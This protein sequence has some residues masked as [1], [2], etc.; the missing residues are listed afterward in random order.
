MNILAIIPA[1]SGSRGIPN[2]NINSFNGKPLI[3]YAIELARKAEKRGLITGHIVSTDS[4]QIASIAKEAGGNVP[5]LRPGEL[6]TDSSAVVGTAVHAVKWWEQSHSEVL[7]SFLLLQP[8]NPL[9]IPEDIEKSVGYYLENQPDARCLIS[10]CV[11]QH[12]RLS[13][14][15]HKKGPYLEQL[16]QDI[17]PLV[18]RQAVSRLYQR[19]GAIYIT[20]RDLLLTEGKII[21][22]RP[23]FYEMPRSRSIAIDDTFDWDLAEFLMKRDN[24]I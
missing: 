5:F 22:G 18:A 23:L 17:D 2:K 12:L 11:A 21:D 3:F 6:A 24:R 10:V 8:T 4:E 15:Y 1:R 13:T 20:R 7:H 14:L 9:T 16:L 19:N